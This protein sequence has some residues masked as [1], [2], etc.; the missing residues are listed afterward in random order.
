VWLGS[1]SVWLKYA[2]AIWYHDDDKSAPCCSSSSSSSSFSIVRR[3]RRGALD[4]Q[5]PRPTTHTRAHASACIIRPT[6]RDRME[7]F[8]L[9]CFV[10]TCFFNDTHPNVPPLVMLHPSLMRQTGGGRGL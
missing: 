2:A 7:S 6:D 8:D 3:R 5:P 10:N 4:A 1:Q 9:E